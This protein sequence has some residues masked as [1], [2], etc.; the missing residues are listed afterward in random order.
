MAKPPHS[1]FLWAAS[2][3]WFTNRGPHARQF[4]FN[5]LLSLSPH[6]LRHC[7]QIEYILRSSLSSLGSPFALATPSSPSS[8]RVPPFTADV[9]VVVSSPSAVTAIH[10][11]TPS[12]LSGGSSPVLDADFRHQCYPKRG[13]ERGD[14][15]SRQWHCRGAHNVGVD[16]RSQGSLGGGAWLPTLRCVTSP[17]H[18]PLAVVHSARSIVCLPVPHWFPPPTTPRRF[19]SPRPPRCRRPRRM[20]LCRGERK[21]EGERSKQRVTCRT[22]YH[23]GECNRHIVGVKDRFGSLIFWQAGQMV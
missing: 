11:C 4:C 22:Q 18:R 10:C 8:S 17:F 7:T 13:R 19:I 20:L 6:T 2:Q 23:I 16:G 9:S 5:S 15:W 21:D 1:S 3:N 14:A 12:P